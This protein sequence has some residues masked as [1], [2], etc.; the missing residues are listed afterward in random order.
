MN[1][2]TIIYPKELLKFEQ[3][4]DAYCKT[5]AKEAGID[6]NEV[7]LDVTNFVKNKLWR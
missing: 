6:Y 3:Q 5:I 7:L 1:T 4:I 2:T